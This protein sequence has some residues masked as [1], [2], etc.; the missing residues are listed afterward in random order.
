[1]ASDDPDSCPR[2]NWALR[3]H[4]PTGGHTANGPSDEQSPHAICPNCR[5][6]L[7]RANGFSG[8]WKLGSPDQAARQRDWVSATR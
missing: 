1:M 2:R 4:T 7:I 3:Q 8:R 5:A 6:R